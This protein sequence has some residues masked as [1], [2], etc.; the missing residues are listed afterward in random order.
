MFIEMGGFGNES[1]PAECVALFLHFNGAL[2][3]K[4]CH[5]EIAGCRFESGL[6]QTQIIC[7]VEVK[8]V[9]N[10]KYKSFKETE[11]LKTMFN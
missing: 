9:W 11:I 8:C 4:R 7:N 10:A 1:D 5:E 3:N 6:F 2:K